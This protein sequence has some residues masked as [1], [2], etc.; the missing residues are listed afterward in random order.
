MRASI[1]FLLALLFTQASATYY[2]RIYFN[3]SSCNASG[4]LY[5]AL[6]GQAAGQTLASCAADVRGCT[7]SEFWLGSEDYT[8]HSH[9]AYVKK[10]ACFDGDIQPSVLSGAWTIDYNDDS[11]GASS[12]GAWQYDEPTCKRPHR[13]TS[14]YDGPVGSYITL[15]TGSN[16]GERRYYAS[17]DC[18]GDAFRAIKLSVSGNFTPGVCSKDGYNQAR[19]QIKGCFG[20]T[21]APWTPSWTPPP[22]PSACPGSSIATTPASSSIACYE[23]MAFDV[24]DAKFANLA[25]VKL[26]APTPTTK[27]CVAVTGVCKYAFGLCAG[28]PRGSPVRFFGGVRFYRGEWWLSEHFSGIPM[29]SLAASIALYFDSTRDIAVCTTDGCNSPLSDACKVGGFSSLS[30]GGALPTLPVASASD[31]KCYDGREEEASATAGNKLCVAFNTFCGNGAAR[32]A[33]WRNPFC[34]AAPHPFNGT[35]RARFPMA[36]LAAVLSAFTARS[37]PATAAGFEAAL[38][39]LGASG[40]ASLTTAAFGPGYPLRKFVNDLVI[41]NTENCNG[42]GADQCAPADRPVQLDLKFAGIPDA[43]ITTDARGKRALVPA[44]VEVLR[45]SIETAVQANACATCSVTLTKV[46]ED[47]TGSTLYEAPTSGARRL[48]AGTSVTTTFATSGGSVAQLAAVTAAASSLAFTATVTS[49][50][51]SNP[52]YSSVT[53]SAPVTPGQIAAALGLLGLLAL[54]V[55]VPAVY[56]FCKKAAAPKTAPTPTGPGAMVINVPPSAGNTTV[57]ITQQQ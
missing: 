8:S 30:C 53:A 26:V 3:D 55:L 13:F 15:C 19:W 54:L 36:K 10:G 48:Q 51:A 2:E 32:A 34:P 18:S 47:A 1:L 46:V 20:S 7:I 27:F 21:V 25:V 41:C 28:L 5:T 37:V 49:V 29:D 57:I 50:V 24:R 31:I 40:G 38:S 35:L 9:R 14:Y 42:G 56:C 52:E 16:D 4:K 44:A 45:A 23:G 6:V 17:K 33:G 12:T 22:L 43:K 11:C 39:G